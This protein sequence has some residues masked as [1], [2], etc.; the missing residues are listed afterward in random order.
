MR[1]NGFASNPNPNPNP[2]LN[3]NLNPN[4]K[5][6]LLVNFTQPNL[7]LDLPNSTGPP[8]FSR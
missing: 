7:T 1:H 8:H 6:S 2:N 4:P 3:L 5:S